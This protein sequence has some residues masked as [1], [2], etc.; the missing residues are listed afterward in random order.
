MIVLNAY[1]ISAR[2]NDKISEWV[3][4]DAN[5]TSSTV[6]IIT[7]KVMMLSY[8]YCG[9]TFNHSN[10]FQQCF[11]GKGEEKAS[12]QKQFGAF[13][14]IFWRVCGV[15]ACALIVHLD[16]TWTACCLLV[17]CLSDNRNNWSPSRVTRSLQ[18]GVVKDMKSK[19][20]Y[21]NLRCTV[22]T[23]HNRKLVD[24][25]TWTV[26]AAQCWVWLS[27]CSCSQ[28]TRGKQWSSEYKIPV[29]ELSERGKCQ[30]SGTIY[31]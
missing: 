28:R 3:I 11:K 12:P 1:I 20:M 10:D 7:M 27:D 22:R 6:I 2:N 19:E 17:W 9:H 24:W 5:A 8:T 23:V 30:K 26:T 29:R 31:V 16:S 4:R 15:I 13:V 25:T 21:N 18:R 14:S